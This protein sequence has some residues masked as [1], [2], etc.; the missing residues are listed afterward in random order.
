MVVWWC[1]G[2]DDQGDCGSGGDGD[3]D[4]DD[5]DGDG[6]D[7]GDDDDDGDG[8]DGELVI[9][10]MIMMMMAIMAR[11]VTLCKQSGLG[12]CE[13]KYN[14][15]MCTYWQWLYKHTVWPFVSFHK[16]RFFQTFT[17]LSIWIQYS[18]KAQ[19][20]QIFSQFCKCAPTIGLSINFIS[21]DSW[22]IQLKLSI[23]EL[24]FCEFSHSLGK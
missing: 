21:N 16:I 10:I 17:I 6:G 1:R 3:D 12:V 11:I 2:D 9:T 15:T 4:D 20:A 22:Y 18:Q 23:I 13:Y 24:D 19:V 5:D 7:G 14:C 8:G